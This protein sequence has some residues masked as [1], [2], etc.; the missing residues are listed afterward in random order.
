MD[1]VHMNLHGITPL[2]TPLNAD[3]KSMEYTNG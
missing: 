1:W 2:A 3:F